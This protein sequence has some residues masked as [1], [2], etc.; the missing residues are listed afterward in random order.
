MEVQFLSYLTDIADVLLSINGLKQCVSLSD[1]EG[2]FLPSNMTVDA[3]AYL[4]AIE[5]RIR[6]HSSIQSLY[7]EFRQRREFGGLILLEDIIQVVILWAHGVCPCLE[8]RSN[9]RG[10][11][12]INKNLD[13]YRETLA[14]YSYHPKVRAS[15]YFLRLNV[16]KEG[17]PV[18]TMINRNIAL[19][20]LDGRVS[21]LGT[22]ID[23]ANIHNKKL[24]LACGSLT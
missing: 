13:S 19:V 15:G 2:Y 21:A 18:G 22:Y 5:E 3:A 16:V 12:V 20:E 24:V 8:L 1:F 7:E 23:L 14:S 6:I 9:H 11:I 4:V 10:T 17:V